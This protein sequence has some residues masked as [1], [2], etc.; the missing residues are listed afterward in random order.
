GDDRKKR[1][2]RFFWQA[3]VEHPLQA[4]S[5]SLFG[6][7]YAHQAETCQWPVNSEPGDLEQ[8]GSV[9]LSFALQSQHD[10]IIDS[11]LANAADAG[12]GQPEERMPP[13]NGLEEG[14]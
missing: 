3:A 12:I 9:S 13:V 4:L 5:Q 2:P 6:L 11:F 1:K 14:L 7:E 10:R 8:R